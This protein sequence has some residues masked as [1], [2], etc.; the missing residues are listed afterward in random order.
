MYNF[1]IGVRETTA[2]LP[3][4]NINEKWTPSADEPPDEPPDVNHILLIDR[5]KKDSKTHQIWI[6]WQKVYKQK[7]ETMV[8]R[9]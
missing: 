1:E 6:E 7:L 5:C 3:K 9:A 2:Q 4:A 8:T